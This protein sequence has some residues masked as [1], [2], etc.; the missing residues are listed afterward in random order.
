MF[1]N[2][3]SLQYTFIG[4][5]PTLDPGIHNGYKVNARATAR[6]SSRRISGR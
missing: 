4:G 2:S 5:V 6:R 1:L 3:Q